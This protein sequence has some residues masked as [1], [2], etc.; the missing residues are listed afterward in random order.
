[1]VMSETRMERLTV[2][3]SLDRRFATYLRGGN[4]KKSHKI[5][6][7]TV[8]LADMGE[9]FQLTAEGFVIFLVNSTCIVQYQDTGIDASR[10]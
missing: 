7:N 4:G 10:E 5:C 8:K 9:D 1:M 3:R 6:I 2:P